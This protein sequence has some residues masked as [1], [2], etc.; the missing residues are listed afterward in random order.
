MRKSKEELKKEVGAE[1][2]E[3]ETSTQTVIEDKSAVLVDPSP[4]RPAMR[5]PVP[6]ARPTEA[7]LAEAAP[8]SYEVVRGGR[9]FHRGNLTVLRPGK[10]IKSNGYNIAQLESQGIELKEI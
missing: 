4:K 3:E 10:T 2:T 1:S 8:K 9:I 5:R 6:V 7:E